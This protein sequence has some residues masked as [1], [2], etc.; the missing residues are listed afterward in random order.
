M[1]IRL[2]TAGGRPPHAVATDIVARAHAVGL[3]AA[4]VYP[5]AQP[6]ET[7]EVAHRTISLSDERALTVTIIDTD[8]KI[9][10]FVP[11]LRALLGGEQ[12]ISLEPVDGPYELS[13]RK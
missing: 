11:Q 13:D 8:E 12:A 10:A 1:T 7:G 9:R 3:L 4:T 2:N 6:D 5:M